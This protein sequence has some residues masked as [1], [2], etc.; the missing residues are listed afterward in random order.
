MLIKRSVGIT[1]SIALILAS[2]A[3]G[4]SQAAQA[5]TSTTLRLD[6]SVRFQTIDGFGV[7]MVDQVPG[8]SGLPYNLASLSPTA[9]NSVEDTLFS[10]SGA[11]LSALRIELGAGATYQNGSSAVPDF[12]IEPNSPGS[13]SATPSYVWD[14]SAD[15]QVQ[16]AKDARAR[17][18]TT[19]LANAWSAPA[20]MKSNGSVYGGTLCGFVTCSSGDWRAAYASYLAQYVKYYQSEGVTIDAVGPFNEPDF[21]APWQSMTG[22]PAQLASFSPILRSALQSAGLSTRI[23]GSDVSDAGQAESFQSAVQADSGAAAAQKIAAFHSYGGTPAAVPAAAV[24]GKPSWQSEYTCVN[25]TW[26]TAYSSGDCSG[27]TWAKHMYTAMAGGL[28]AYFAWTGAWSHTD[29]EDLIR[30]TGSSTYAVSSRLWVMGNYSRFVRPGAVRLESYTPSQDLLATAY[31]NTNGS[32]AV[33]LTNVS[34]QAVNVAMSGVNGGTTVGYVTD[35]TRSLSAQPAQ[36]LASSGATTLS[37]PA[38][39]TETFLI[40]G[41]SDGAAASYTL[42]NANS[43][44]VLSI[45]DSSSADG[46]TLWQFTDYGVPAQRWTLSPIDG[47]FYEIT[48]AGNGKAVSVQNSSTSDDATV[49]QYSNFHVAAQQWKLLSVGGGRLILQGRGSGL[50]LSIRG[51]GTGDGGVTNQFHLVDSPSQLWTLKPN[52]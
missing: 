28:N 7:S 36:S 33:V 18:V 8:T 48:N 32:T 11:S 42:T 29:N 39:S 20:F 40:S 4:G 50:L 38:S 43:S 47:G 30:I 14:H 10:S 6:P 51:S 26:N 45:E 13:P 1:M 34:N 25:D 46:A 9:R 3:V 27:Q 2:A 16:I 15:G 41:S 12:T 44:K 31:R 21:S 5:A 24:A 17:G 19:V 23:T 52:G 22:S 37:V 49:W 35:D